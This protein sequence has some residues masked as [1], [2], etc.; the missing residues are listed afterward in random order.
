MLI[1]G[2]TNVLAKDALV[3]NGFYNPF[4]WN[5]VTMF[6][7]M[8]CYPIY[9]LLRE[10]A[11][12]PAASKAA[13]LAT[14]KKPMAPFR[15][16]VMVTLIDLAALSTINFTYNALPGS[17]I[18]MLRGCKVAFTCILSK[19][20]LGTSF[21]APKLVGIAMNFVG[22]LFVIVSS[23][24]SMWDAD[25]ARKPMVLQALCIGVVSQLIGSFQFIFEKKTMESYDVPP[26]LLASYEGMIGL[27]V[28]CVTLVIANMVGYEDTIV[29]LQEID[30]TA[31]IRG[32]MILF[33]FAVATFNLAG[34]SVAKHGSPVLRALLEIMRTAVIWT[35]EVA[36][37]WLRFETTE[38]FA[39]LLTSTGTLIYGKQIP[40]PC[41]RATK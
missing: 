23:T 29:A 40:L 24:D 2:S 8:C 22:L 32:L 4:L 11:D 12:P 38:L 15:L 16:L 17:L 30:S 34:I 10:S 36:R 19:I 21:D 35:L 18:Q 13:L 26:L 14:N 6:G 20:I 39:Y 31:V 33:L 7:Q 1:F 5:C 9:L 3:V 27:P 25:G 28:A 37:G 41:I